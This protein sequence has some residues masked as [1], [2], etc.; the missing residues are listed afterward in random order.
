M[1]SG[2]WT[3][4]I[5][6]KTQSNQ[7]IILPNIRVLP[8]SGLFSWA[9][10]MLPGCQGSFQSLCADVSTTSTN[11]PFPSLEH[12]HCRADD[13]YCLQCLAGPQNCSLLLNLVILPLLL[14]MDSLTTVVLNLNIPVF[15][16]TALTLAF[17]VVFFSW[18]WSCSLLLQP[19]TP[20]KTSLTLFLSLPPSAETSGEEFSNSWH[21]VKK[22]I[23]SQPW[24]FLKKKKKK[25]PTTFSHLFFHHTCTYECICVCSC[26]GHQRGNWNIFNS[27]I[28]AVPNSLTKG[29]QSLQWQ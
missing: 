2:E 7:N 15:L 9:P 23:P 18:Y 8:C 20:Y 13:C 26:W 5:P 21:P 27:W 17:L 19:F 12:L 3:R 4:S 10:G 29:N 16:L 11:M 22:K 1:L 14:H 6:S 24:H 25:K 28:S